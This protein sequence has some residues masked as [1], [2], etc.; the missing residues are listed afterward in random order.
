[1]EK[2]KKMPT[3]KPCFTFETYHEGENKI[4]KIDATNC[5]FPPSIEYSEVCMGKV[6]DALQSVTGVNIIIISQLREYEYDYSQTQLLREV[7][8]FYRK[9]TKEDRSAHS[10]IIVDQ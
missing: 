4:L 9:I 2:S 7:A 6:I 1:M 3:D 10:K 5:P 8:Q